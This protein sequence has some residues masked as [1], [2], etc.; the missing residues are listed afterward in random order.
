[1]DLIKAREYALEETEGFEKEHGNTVQMELED[2]RDCLMDA[3]A[4]GQDEREEQILSH[5]D[6]KMIIAYEAGQEAFSA[7]ILN[8]A[9][10]MWAGVFLRWIEEIC[11]KEAKDG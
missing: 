4:A 3:D 1:M 10:N 2:F 5:P 8:Q 6:V 11:G 7:R 9:R